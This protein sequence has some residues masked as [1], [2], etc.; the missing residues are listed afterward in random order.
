PPPLRGGSGS[1]PGTGG[2]K[3]ESEGQMDRFLI[4]ER[5]APGQGPGDPE[6]KS[7]VA[8]A[9]PDRGPVQLRSAAEDVPAPNR[10]AVLSP[11]GDFRAD[12]DGGASG[13]SHAVLH[14]DD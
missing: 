3:D 8:Q 10:D 13:V 9:E 14:F 5:T 12:E 6:L 7:L 4:E 1:Y 11:Q 2:S